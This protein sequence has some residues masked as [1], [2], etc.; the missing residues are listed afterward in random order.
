MT[1]SNFKYVLE[2]ECTEITLEISSFWIKKL[3]FQQNFWTEPEIELKR[4]VFSCKMKW[5]DHQL[6]RIEDHQCIWLGGK[7]DCFI[8]SK[9]RQSTNQFVEN[10][11][12]V[13]EGMKC[14]HLGKKFSHL[15]SGPT[16]DSNHLLC[17]WLNLS[18]FRHES[19]IINDNDL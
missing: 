15:S 8:P 12:R 14:Q 7:L 2:T 19:S 4:M 9:L 5:L 1:R 18:I 17:N 11:T 13:V 6:F 3:P 10:K 16:A